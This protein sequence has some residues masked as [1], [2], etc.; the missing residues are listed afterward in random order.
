M[1]Q[2]EKLIRRI[3]RRGDQKAAGLLVERYY[4][5]IWMDMGR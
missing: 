1:E 2:E 4:E 5:E 3:V